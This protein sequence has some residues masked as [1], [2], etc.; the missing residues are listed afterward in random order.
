MTDKIYPLKFTPIF[1]EKVWGGTRLKDILNK[2]IPFNTLIGESWELTDRAHDVSIINNGYYA[3]KSLRVPMY[4]LGDSLLGTQKA[5]DAWGRFP[6]LVKFL[7][8]SEKLSVQVHPNDKQAQ[9]FEEDDPGKTEMWYVLYAEPHAKIIYG[10]DKKV[11]DT[12]THNTVDSSI[13]SLLHSYT[14]QAGDFIFV[15]AGQIHTMYG[16]CVILEIQQNSDVTYRIY[17]WG[18][19]GLDGLPRPL[20]IAKSL[21]CI[22]Y[23]KPKNHIQHLAHITESSIKLIDCPYFKAH[24]VSTS[25]QFTDDCSGKMFKIIAPVYGE[26]SIVFDKTKNISFRVGDIILLPAALGNYTIIPVSTI[27]FLLIS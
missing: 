1:K 20:H 3:G 13:E 16:G 5:C 14:I 23:E 6:L 18:R 8:A 4:E 19:V 7:D 26:G 12:F 21:E 10:C 27:R 15:P 11:A 9:Q 2:D 24:Y 22:D 17:D 25:K